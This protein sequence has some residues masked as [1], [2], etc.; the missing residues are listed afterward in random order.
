MVRDAKVDVVLQRVEEKVEKGLKL[1]PEKIRRYGVNNIFTRTF[2]YLLGWTVEDEPVKLRATTAGDL[3]VTA[4]R[5]GLEYI[6]RYTGTAGVHES[7]V[8]SLN[9]RA[10]WFSIY[11][12]DAPLFLRVMMPGGI[13]SDQIFCRGDEVTVFELE[14]QQFKFQRAGGTITPFVLTGIS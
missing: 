12:Y 1:I 10:N 4:T 2:S 11:P 5:L 9:R 8:V 6:E 13:W 14:A 7:A 3:K